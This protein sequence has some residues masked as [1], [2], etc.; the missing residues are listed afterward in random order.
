MTK[1]QKDPV[2]IDDNLSEEPGPESVAQQLRELE[3]M[4]KYMQHIRVPTS[5]QN[6]NLNLSLELATDDYLSLN[7]TKSGGDKAYTLA[8][9][10][11]E[12]RGITETV[13]EEREELD[14]DIQGSNY[15]MVDEVYENMN[16]FDKRLKSLVR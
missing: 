6:S 4:N 5:N 7:G 9:L 1:T 2:D 15:D 12:E 10:R 13:T 16:S 11:R 14:S 8:R 3:G